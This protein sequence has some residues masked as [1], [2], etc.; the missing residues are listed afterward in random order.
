MVNEVKKVTRIH[1]KKLLTPLEL[2]IRRR[3]SRLRGNE[4]RIARLR[5][6][7]DAEVSKLERRNEV[8]RQIL[9]ALLPAKQEKKS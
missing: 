8:H 5:Q 3:E 9:A 1:S 4:N 6:Q 2:E 7:C